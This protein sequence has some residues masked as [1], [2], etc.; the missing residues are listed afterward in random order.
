MKGGRGAVLCSDRSAAKCFG[1]RFM[2]LVA[3][4]FVNG[5]DTLP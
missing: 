3:C 1:G 5:V 4:C 2:D